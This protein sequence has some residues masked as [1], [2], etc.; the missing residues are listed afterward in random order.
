[1]MGDGMRSR[2]RADLSSGL[3]PSALPVDSLNLG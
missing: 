1:M 2:A 3:V